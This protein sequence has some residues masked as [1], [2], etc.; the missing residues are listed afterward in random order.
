[1]DITGAVATNDSIE[2]EQH[3][4]HSIDDVWLA[5]SEADRI[6]TWFIQA[7]FA[8]KVGYAYTFTH[9][10]TTVTGKVLEVEPPR[11]L[12]YTW[13][14]GDTGVETIVSWTLTASNDGTLLRIEHTGFERY[15]D[16]APVM[17]KSST[18][19]WTAVATELMKYLDHLNDE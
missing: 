1:M 8:A 14:V 7:D 15:A 18:G 9:E 10:S 2:L 4:P 11:R 3:Y 13:I 17:I 5:I 16:T 6:S 12:V 19:G